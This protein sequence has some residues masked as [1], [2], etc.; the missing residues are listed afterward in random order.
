MNLSFVL[1]VVSLSWTACSK[2]TNTAVID[3]TND[4]TFKVY[5]EGMVT[6]VQNLNAD[7]I[8][9]IAPT[10]QPYGSG[11]FTFFSLATRSVVPSSDSASQKW[12]IAFRGTNIL[13]NGGTSGPGGGGAFIWNGA[14]DNLGTIPAD[15]VFRVDNAPTYAIT[16]GSGKGWYNY[17]GPANLI[18]PLPGRVLVIRTANGKY[19]KLEILNYYRKGQTPSPSDT[20]AIK[21]KNQRFYLFRYSYQGNGSAAF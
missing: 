12:D 1:A 10:G 21:M 3:K 5:T 4:G 8:I 15:S 16:S 19:A 18:T 6:T 17:D 13:I 2:E 9:G 20:D 14:F 11:R 7:T